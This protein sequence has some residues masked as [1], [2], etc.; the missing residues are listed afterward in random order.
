M[1]CLKKNG[2]NCSLPNCK[3]TDY[4]FDSVKKWLKKSV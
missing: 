1:I 4:F 2:A 3:Y